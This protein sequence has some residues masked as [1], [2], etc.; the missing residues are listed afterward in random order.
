MRGVIR[1]SLDELRRRSP[2]HEGSLAQ[3]SAP[4]IDDGPDRSVHTRFDHGLAEF[5]AFRFGKRRMQSDE[6]T[7][8]LAGRVLLGLDTDASQL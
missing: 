5:P 1:E 8:E 2:K 3:A 6:G 7:Y 4:P